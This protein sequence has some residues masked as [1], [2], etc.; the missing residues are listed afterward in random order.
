LWFLG[1]EILNSDGQQFHQYQQNFQLLRGEDP[2]N[3]LNL[4]ICCDCTTP[5]PGIATSCHGLFYVHWVEVK[6]D[7]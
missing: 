1:E 6:D 7:C 3:W 4:T 2:I 5:G